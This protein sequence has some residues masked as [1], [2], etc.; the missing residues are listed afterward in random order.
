MDTALLRCFLTICD[1]RS[2]SVA[3]QRLNVTQST[4]S[5]Q[6]GRLEDLLGVELFTRTT[7]SCALTREGS[8]LIPIASKIMRLVEEMNETF[9]GAVE[10]AS[11]DFKAA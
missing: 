11:K 8:E 9:K 10:K 2:F 7:R 5:H 4:V 3:A 1:T 6:L